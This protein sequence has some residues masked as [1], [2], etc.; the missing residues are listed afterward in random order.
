M[1][2]SSG[3]ERRVSKALYPE[4]KYQAVVIDTINALQNNLYSDMMNGRKGTYDQWKDFG[5]EIYELY[6]WIKNL[7]DVVLV[8]VL[9][10]EGTGKTVGA[11][12]L[13]PESTQYFNADGKPLSFFGA[14]KMYRDNVTPEEKAQGK[15]ANLRVPHDYDQVKDW[16]GKIHQ[17]RRGTLVVFI[18]GHIEN[19]NLPLGGVGQRLKVLGKQATKLGI[20]GL[21]VIHTYYTKIDSTYQPTDA[22]RYKL[23]VFNSG[24]N[25]ARSPEGYWNGDIPNNYQLILERILED[26][27]E[28]E[29]K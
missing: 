3:V 18:L 27:G 21:N 26:T 15:R 11:K 24:F 10:P 4:G 1:T 22:Q 13:D 20:E 8:Q 12:Y 17:A 2:M 6:K 5:I 7:P 14:K 25:T 29:E 19:Y 9:G 16:L 23:E 28:L